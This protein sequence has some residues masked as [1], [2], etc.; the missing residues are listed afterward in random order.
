MALT[1]RIT[2]LTN[3][4]NQITM[5]LTT[6]IYLAAVMRHERFAHTDL[7]S[8]RAYVSGGCALDEDLRTKFREY[9]PNGDVYNCYGSSEL[10]AAVTFNCP[11][12][13]HS[14]GML[15]NGMDA[16]LVDISGNRCGIGEIG[17][18]CL[19]MPL[20][21]EKY[22]GVDETSQSAFD[23][24]GWYMT[25]DMGYFDADG[26]LF[27]KGRKNELLISD[28]CHIFSCEVEAILLK[29]PQIERACIVG[30]P[31]KQH[32]CVLAAAIVTYGQGQITESD[33]VEFLKGWSNDISVPAFL[34]N[35]DH[36]HRP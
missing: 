29:H 8:L 33:V 30:I 7:S 10:F 20:M 3:L 36:F 17:E 27:I 13:P 32:G 25:G 16:K 26:Y 23:G 15:C 28:N 1:A 12:K 5:T 22:L 24:D 14:V 19:K 2:H 18:I 4:I 31:S 21:F 11:P 6:P 9:L 35:Y 34:I